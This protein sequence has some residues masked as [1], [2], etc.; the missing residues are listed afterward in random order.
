MTP[1]REREHTS[2]LFSHAVVTGS[3]FTAR[4]HAISKSVL[5][6]SLALCAAGHEQRGGLLRN[7]D[8]HQIIPTHGGDYLYGSSNTFNRRQPLGF[9]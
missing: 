5:L 1:V 2:F 4:P 3:R 9:V 7:V 8:P 6:C